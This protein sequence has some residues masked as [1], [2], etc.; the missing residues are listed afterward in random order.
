MISQLLYAPECCLTPKS[1]LQL[2]NVTW[3]HHELCRELITHPIDKF[4]FHDLVVH[5]PPQYQIV[6][7]RSTN[8]ES[9]ERLFKHISQRATNRKPDN[10]LSTILLS[11]PAKEE[12]GTSSTISCI[13]KQ[14]SRIG[15]KTSTIQH[16]SQAFLQSRMPSWQAH[17]QH[18]STY[19]QY[20][21]GVWWNTFEDGYLFLDSDSDSPTH[22]SGPMLKHF[23]NTSIQAIRDQSEATWKTIVELKTTLPTPYIWVYEIGEYAGRHHFTSEIDEHSEN[24][25]DPTGHSTPTGSTCTSTTST[26]TP[27]N[28]SVHTTEHDVSPE[29]CS[30]A[31]N[32][33]P[34]L[35]FICSQKFN[36]S[37]QD[38][39]NSAQQPSESQTLVGEITSDQPEETEMIICDIDAQQDSDNMDDSNSNQQSNWRTRKQ[40][41]TSVDKLRALLRLKSTEKG[42]RPSSALKTQYN[43]IIVSKA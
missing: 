42:Y 11:M 34:T 19:L 9:T 23:R 15:E 2:Y 7:L 26:P 14:T 24:Q 33:I 25:A 10:V 17:L 20:G 31:Q 3:L 29:S 4:Y 5:A 21:E 41:T 16:I 32:F 36:S 27:P 8:A 1:V 37:S 38:T 39:L 40:I 6:C 12:T 13:R 22:Q 43:V 28:T 35:N 30:V 18:I